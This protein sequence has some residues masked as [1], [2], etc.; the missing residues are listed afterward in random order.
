LKFEV[1]APVLTVIILG[2]GTAHQIY[3]IV[4]LNNSDQ[5]SLLKTALGLLIG[6]VWLCYGIE[7]RSPFI[8]ACNVV[9]VSLG[10]A[11]MM[12]I[13]RFRRRQ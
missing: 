2:I 4:K 7:V 3:L 9:T 13:Y 6:V 1:I 5:L 10:I 8:I 12:V 11:L